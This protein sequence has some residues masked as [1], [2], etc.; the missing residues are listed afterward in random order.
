MNATWELIEQDDDD[1]LRKLL[2]SGFGVDGV[3]GKQFF[4]RRIRS[5]SFPASV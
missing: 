1:S 5:D 3:A 2:D 4:Q